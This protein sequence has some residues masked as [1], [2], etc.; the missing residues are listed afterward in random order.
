MEIKH[1]SYWLRW[2]GKQKLSQRAGQ[3]GIDPFAVFISQRRLAKPNSEQGDPVITWTTMLK[4][5]LVHN[6]SLALRPEVNVNK[7][8]DAGIELNL[9]PASTSA[10]VFVL[11]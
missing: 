10:S 7:Y 5:S 4:L 3:S 9:I 8:V 11:H 2:Y 1:R 6:I